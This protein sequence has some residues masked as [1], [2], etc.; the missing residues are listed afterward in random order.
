MAVTELH[1]ANDDKEFNIVLLL[2]FYLSNIF[3]MFDHFAAECL[4]MLSRKTQ[5]RFLI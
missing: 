1:R 3:D 2:L 4:S 5:K